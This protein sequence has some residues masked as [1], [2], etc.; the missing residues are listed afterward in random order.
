MHPQF[1]LDAIAMRQHELELAARR[2]R[3]VKRQP[4]LE[5]VSDDSV[6]LRLCTVKD[7]AAIARLAALEGRPLPEGP[8]VIGEVAGE[9]VAALPLHGGEALAD[10]FRYTEH[11]LTLMRMR[12]HQLE[13]AGRFSRGARRRGFLRARA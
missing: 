9:V 10:P 5:R 8:L 7:D 4:A 3:L 13:R 12:A 6:M 11:L 1:R 2:A